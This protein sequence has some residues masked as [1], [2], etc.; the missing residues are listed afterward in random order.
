MPG[1]WKKVAVKI[2]QTA[3]VVRREGKVGGRAT[4]T[5]ELVGELVRIQFTYGSSSHL[6]QTVWLTDEASRVLSSLLADTVA[7][8]TT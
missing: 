8:L 3:K 1:V 5:V 7:L 2:D 6:T 4:I